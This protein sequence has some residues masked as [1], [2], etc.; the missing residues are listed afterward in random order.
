MPRSDGRDEAGETHWDG[1]DVL[2]E[3]KYVPDKCP[4]TVISGDFV[5]YHYHGTL[6]DGKKFDSSQ[7]L[8]LNHLAGNLCFPN[9]SFHF[10]PEVKCL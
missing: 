8:T 7:L 2:I 9:K 4:R 5:R 3:R 1:K 10:S 6:S